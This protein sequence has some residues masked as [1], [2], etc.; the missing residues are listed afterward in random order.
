MAV[1]SNRVIGIVLAGDVNAPNMA[2]PA[3]ENVLSPGAIQ[4]TELTAGANTIAVPSD[5]VAV[6]ILPPAGNTIGITLKGIS[7]DTGVILH[8]TDPTSL[9][10]S[11]GVSSFVLTA[12]GGSATVRFIWT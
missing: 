4:V 8:P 10:L 6:T 11:S 5:S 2:Y 7:A 12:F 1:T 3:A 9:G